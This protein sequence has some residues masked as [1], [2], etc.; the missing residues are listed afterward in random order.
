[1]IS[2]PEHPVKLCPCGANEAAVRLQEYESARTADE[3]D[4][5]R[6]IRNVKAYASID[7]DQWPADLAS[8]VKNEG[9]E[10]KTYN[11]LQM[12]VDGV[13]G[14]FMANWV[15]PKF[16]DRE[17]DDKNVMA[18]LDGLQKIWYADKEHF[19]YKHSAFNC[20]IN[21]NIYRG[22][23][24]LRV[25]R[26]SSEP[27]GRLKFDSL[28]PDL[29]TF[30]QNNISDQI[31]RAAQRA[32]K[33][34][35]LTGAQAL[36]FFPHMEGRMKDA[37]REYAKTD[38]T[39]GKRYEATTVGEFEF[40]RLMFGSSFQF[41][42]D[43]HIE[44]DKRNVAMH[45]RVGKR[46]PET[47]YEFGT[48]DD[49]MAKKVWAD[50]QGWGLE[51]EDITVIRESVPT[52]YV[53]TIC[54]QLG[55][56]VENRRDERQLLDE[57]GICHLPF[58]VWALI[59]KNGKTTGLVDIGYDSQQDI[60]RRELHKTKLF[61]QSPI[62][63]KSWIHPMAYGDGA[64]AKRDAVD[65]LND[66]SKPLVLSEDAPPGMALFG[67]AQGTNIP[68]SFFTEETTKLQF[69]DRM[70]RLPSAM[71]GMAG[72]SGESGVLFGRKV[73]EG[74]V[75]QR[76]PASTLEMH[77]NHKAE[78]WVRMAIRLYG[79]RTPAQRASNFNRKF[80]Q[81]GGDTTVV[82]RHVGNDEMGNPIVEADISSLKRV[83][84]IISQARDS[85]YMKQ[86]KREVL[87][88]E[89]Q[90]MPPSDTNLLQRT[91]RETELS[92]SMDVTDETVKERIETANELSY[93][94][95]IKTTMVRIQALDQQLNPAPAAP[96]PASVAENAPGSSGP[97]DEVPAAMPGPE[98]IGQG[99][100][101][102]FTRP[103]VP[104]PARVV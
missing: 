15:D 43:F 33:T 37:F 19:D 51:P 80:H 61:T 41:I 94:L 56:I 12:F 92:S 48:F 58:Y 103:S 10:I 86:A 62:G 81:K 72:K 84:V 98:G 28:R 74:N 46:L 9:R 1:L 13:A 69:L 95:A 66:S 99:T 5:K 50:A 8:E 30:D 36:Q 83:D 29:I 70:L 7:D 90:A 101:D 11:F 78:D 25:I 89:L 24:E 44:Y 65:N 21:G 23:E 52:L 88:G 57:E 96:P 4:R 49:F 39:M 77:E 85:D 64:Q 34:F 75:L 18:A 16:V 14:N 71:Q 26:S 68:S 54:K 27:R 100:E 47:P 97:T 79:G 17:D 32:F 59:M 67:V 38:A 40:D 35:Y 55:L 87:I 53:T 76:A 93:E 63:G 20:V 73:I 91:I 102:A 82:N 31:S 2:F 45:R 42:E 60:N 3:K 6:G 22:V 104:Q